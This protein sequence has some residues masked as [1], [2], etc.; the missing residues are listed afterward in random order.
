[1][2]VLG[3]ALVLAVAAC[4]SASGDSASPNQST[5][6]T[7]STAPPTTATTTIEATGTIPPSGAPTFWPAQADGSLPFTGTYTTEGDLSG[8]VSGSGTLSIDSAKSTFTQ[9][10]TTATFDGTLAGVGRGNLTFVTTI[11]ETSITA[12]TVVESG[13]VSGGTADLAGLT[14]TIEMHYAVNADGSEGA[15]NY[16]VKLTRDS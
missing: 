4:S 7:S 12:P 5:T 3:V 16:I 14:G 9:H 1:M 2:V 8:T 10:E 15:G 13:T 11:P 6:S